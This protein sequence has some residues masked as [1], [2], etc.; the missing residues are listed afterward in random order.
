MPGAIP[1]LGQIRRSSCRQGGSG[2]LRGGSR[3][4]RSG[5]RNGGRPDCGR[6][7][8]LIRADREAGG[9]LFRIVVVGCERRPRDGVDAGGGVLVHRAAQGLAVEVVQIELAFADLRACGVANRKAALLRAQF[10][11]EDQCDLG[12]WLVELRAI[13]GIGR[14]QL[15]VGERAPDESKAQAQRQYDPSECS[16]VHAVKPPNHVFKH[17]RGMALRQRRARCPPETCA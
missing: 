16:S 2:R 13:L 4:S 3:P 11:A 7:L 17:T 12:R 6:R 15:G 9:T 14:D 10:F 1:S 5:L 8:R